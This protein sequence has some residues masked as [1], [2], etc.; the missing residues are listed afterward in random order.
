MRLVP[1]LTLGLGLIGACQ[2]GTHAKNYAPARGPAGAILDLRFSD[3]SRAR[4]E[5]LAVEDSALLVV[6]NAQ[7][8]RVPLAQIRSARGPKVAFDSRLR[9]DT[10]ERLRL[11]SRYPQGVSP[12]MEGRLLQA[13]GQSTVRSLP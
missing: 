13:Y 9:S 4:A 5:L 7:L 10:R 2:I 3:K 11:L 6:E 1:V 8:A 12:E